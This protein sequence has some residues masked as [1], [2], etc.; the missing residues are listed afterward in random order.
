VLG[1]LARVS[2]FLGLDR[3][4]HGMD[5]ALGRVPPRTNPGA[6]PDEQPPAFSPSTGAG[7]P[8]PSTRPSPSAGRT[9]PPSPSASPSPSLPAGA[10][11]LARPTKDDRLRVLVLGDSIAADLG[12]GVS[13]LLDPSRFVTK[14]DAR[15]STGLARPDYFDWPAQTAQDVAT[16]QPDVVVVMFGANDNQG[17]LMGDAGVAFGTSAWRA[18]YSRRVGELMEQA[19][20]S[21]SAVAWVGMPTMSSASLGASM[22]TLNGIYEAQAAR[23]PGVVYVDSWALFS[24]PNGRY[25]AFLPNGSGRQELVRQPDGVHLTAAGD[26]RLARHVIDVLELLWTPASPPAPT[27]E[28]SPVEPAAR[29]DLT[30][31]APGP[32][33]RLVT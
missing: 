8:A 19:A 4:Q 18:E 11:I 7:S 16:F 20:S 10:P 21:G 12:I 14:L 29:V 2:A 13:R 6:F 30:P 26:V 25:S 27:P 15:E 24:G 32:D 22:R 33:G 5:A 3:P 17:F 31:S 9:A 23:H 1:P 28:T